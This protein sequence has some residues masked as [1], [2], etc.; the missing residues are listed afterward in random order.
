MKQVLIKTSILVLFGILF[1]S[2][3]VFVSSKSTTKTHKDYLEESDYYFEGVIID[4]FELAVDYYRILIIQVDSIDLKKTL[5]HNY[6]AAYNREANTVV[7]FTAVAPYI[8]DSTDLMPSYIIVDSKSNSVKYNDSFIGS[9]GTCKT[10][11][12]L[13]LYKK[14]FEEFLASRKGPWLRF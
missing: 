3:V 9:P 7:F 14:D 1:I 10:I 5:H 13:G 11:Q 2:V 8:S 6:V 4:E 12:T